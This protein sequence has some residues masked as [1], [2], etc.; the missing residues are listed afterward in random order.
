[1]PPHAADDRK[2]ELQYCTQWKDRKG[3]SREHVKNRVAADDILL[4]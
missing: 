3:D 2:A 4:N 1:M